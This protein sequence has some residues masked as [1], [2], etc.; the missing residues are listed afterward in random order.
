MVYSPNAA[1]G[2]LSQHGEKKKTLVLWQIL[3]IGT[4]TNYVECFTKC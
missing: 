3:I 4:I 1:L 2:L